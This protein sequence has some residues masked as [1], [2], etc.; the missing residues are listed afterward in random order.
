MSY[1][2]YLTDET[3]SLSYEDSISSA[4]FGS[5]SLIGLC[6]IPSAEKMLYLFCEKVSCI[7]LL[8]T[9]RARF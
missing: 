5:T 9:L 2:L 6:E 1:K 8:V 4:K 7:Y 3:K